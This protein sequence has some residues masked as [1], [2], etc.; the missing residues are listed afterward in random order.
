MPDGLALARVLRDGAEDQARPFTAM[1]GAIVS[2]A[3]LFAATFSDPREAVKGLVPEGLTVLAGRPKLG[4]SWL[5]LN[6]ASYVALGLRALGKFE[7]TKGTTLYYAL[8]DNRRRLQR[9]LKTMFPTGGAPAGMGLSV[10]LPRLNDGGIDALE[11]ALD[12]RPDCRLVVVDTLARIRPPKKKNED[13][14][15]ADA[16]FGA[17]LQKI[18]FE[19]SLGLVIVHHLRK[20]ESEDV[21]E[22][23]SGTT[24]LTGSADAIL[25]LERQRGTSDAVLHATGRDIEEAEYALRFDS[26]LGSWSCL[27]AAQEVRLT[28][29]R[30]EVIDLLRRAPGAMTPKEIA[31]LLGKPA[32]AVRGL[33]WKMSKDG[34]VRVGLKT[35]TYVPA[36]Y[37][38]G[39]P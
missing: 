23:V 18:A 26:T 10:S 3:D 38:G 37:E 34:H 35:G 27:G 14:Y 12:L 36:S 4:K 24:G 21:F 9:R 8:E 17:R 15:Q 16:D 25:V 19:R 13:S 29:E 31:E 33:L 5:A 11:G 32:G 7:V 2:A 30:Q 28:R 22:R 6:L 39:R 20:A 1:D